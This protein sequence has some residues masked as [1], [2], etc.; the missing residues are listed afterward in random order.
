MSTLTLR[1]VEIDSAVLVEHTN[2]QHSCKVLVEAVHQE[3]FGILRTIHDITWG[4]EV[5]TSC[6][7]SYQCGNDCL[8]VSLYSSSSQSLCKAL[9]L[10]VSSLQSYKFTLSLL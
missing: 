3:D 8:E 5:L 6:A 4:H 10:L 2:Y 1:T 9:E 7:E